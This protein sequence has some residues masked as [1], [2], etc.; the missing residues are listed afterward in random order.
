ME[1][2]GRHLMN[3]VP[4]V[5][6][7]KGQHTR[8][9]IAMTTTAA[10]K[11]RSRRKSGTSIPLENK[12]AHKTAKAGAIGLGAW[13]AGKAILS[14]VRFT[15]GTALVVAAGIAAVKFVPKPVQRQIANN[16]RDT[17]RLASSKVAEQV[18]AYAA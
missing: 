13:F 10:K 9:G 16:V 5:A 14:V 17:A 12:T 4:T 11:S 1:H 2:A 8:G 6:F 15:I 3:Q 7:P 18:R